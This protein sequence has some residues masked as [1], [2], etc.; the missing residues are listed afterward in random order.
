MLRM[1]DKPVV[2]VVVVGIILRK[3]QGP[4]KASLSVYV[5][6]RSDFAFI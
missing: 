4:I 3:R 6:A 5:F 1:R 2:V